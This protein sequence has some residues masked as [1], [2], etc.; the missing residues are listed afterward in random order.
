MALLAMTTA[1]PAGGQHAHRVRPL[2]NAGPMQ[3]HWGNIGSAAAGLATL[4]VTVRLLWSAP[5]WYR[6]WKD[7]QNAERDLAREQ[8]GAI[9]LERRRHLSGWSGH[10]VDT[11]G[12]TAVTAEDELGRACAELAADQRSA[13]VVM[14][15]SEGGDGHDADRARSLQQIIEAGGYISRPPTAG[16]REALETGLDA[17]GIPR[18]AYGQIRPA[19]A[20][21]DGQR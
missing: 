10:G 11:F 21:Q 2:W 14:R 16:E 5:D 19:R 12:V 13:Y 7:R 1:F 4:I 18:A 6:T 3:W 17:M 15:V 20:Q 9:Q 8:T